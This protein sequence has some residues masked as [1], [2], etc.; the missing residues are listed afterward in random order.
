M[1]NST[2]PVP[3]ADIRTVKKQLI[4]N[5]LTGFTWYGHRIILHHPTKIDIDIEFRDGV[6]TLNPVSPHSEMYYSVSYGAGQGLIEIIINWCI[7]FFRKWYYKDEINA[8]KKNLEA[9]LY[10]NEKISI[11]STFTGTSKVIE[12]M[13]ARLTTAGFG[14]TAFPKKIIVHRKKEHVVIKQ[15]KE[16]LSMKSAIATEKYI[17]FSVLAFIAFIYLWFFKESIDLET[18]LIVFTIC[19]YAGFIFI[20][21]NRTT[22]LKL[23]IE[24]ALKMIKKD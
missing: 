11:S 2:K 14:F 23:D 16:G 12:D 22:D 6:L 7:Y 3:I 24:K 5:G 1:N 8:F 19:A 17:L 21:R 15:R 10:A 18:V 20:A 13:K 9:S 4:K